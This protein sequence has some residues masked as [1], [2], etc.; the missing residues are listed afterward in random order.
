MPGLYAVG[1][2]SCTGLH[3]ANRLAS[4]SL[5]ECFVFARR[6]VAHALSAPV[7]T[8]EPPGEGEIERLLELPA[9][10]VAD[11]GTR[12]AL[13]LDAGI[14]RSPARD[15]PAARRAAPAEPPDRPLRPRAGREPGSTPAGDHPR[16]D[17]ALD[18]RHVV[19]DGDGSIAWQDLGL[20]PRAGGST[21]A[22]SGNPST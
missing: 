8:R 4:N 6:A 19:V 12:E 13:W 18:H 5:S 3:G 14:V 11:P 7:S 1:E 20:N 22:S 15:C 16:S 17:P 9:P 10:P 2:C 21:S